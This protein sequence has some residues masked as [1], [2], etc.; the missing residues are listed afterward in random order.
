[1]H[2]QKDNVRIISYHTTTGKKS[3]FI[4]HQQLSMIKEVLNTAIPNLLE[5]FYTLIL[6]KKSKQTLAHNNMQRGKR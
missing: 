3:N 2:I 4:Y 5:H 1:M 6:R